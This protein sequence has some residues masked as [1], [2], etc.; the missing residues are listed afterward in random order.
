M[1]KAYVETL[2]TESI[3][4]EVQ[5]KKKKRIEAFFHE[6]KN[7]T[8][9]K[10]FMKENADTEFI[11]LNLT[12]D[13]IKQAVEMTVKDFHVLQKDEYYKDSPES[14][15]VESIAENNLEFNMNVKYTET[16]L[17]QV[18][19]LSKVELQA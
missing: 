9:L 19:E 11:F 6:F 5:V 16:D 14:I 12:T 17:K 7:T 13:Q 4:V 10:V 15:T 8:D 1:N 18:I 2:S 3:L